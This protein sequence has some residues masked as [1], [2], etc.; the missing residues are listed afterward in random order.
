ML[1]RSVG[2]YLAGFLRENCVFDDE[3][4]RRSRARRTEAI[5]A[6]DHYESG[7]VIVKR[8]QL[9]DGRARAALDELKVRTEADGSKAR[10]QEERF[11]AE[12]AVRQLREEAA[13]A[14][15]ESAHFSAQNRW[16]LSG[17]LLIAL[18][19]SLAFWHLA[20]A[21]RRHSLLPVPT[22]RAGTAWTG[23]PAGDEEA[24][25]WRARALSAE[26]QAAQ[27]SAVVRAGLLPQFAR[28]LR[29]RLVRGLL[30][31][32]SHL[33]NT[34]ETAELEMAELER[35]LAELQAPLEQRL[36]AYQERI[37][38]LEQELT[39]KG[40]ENRELIKAKIELTRKKLASEQGQD[41]AKWN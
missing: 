12:T 13:R 33:L 24:A 1:A 2:R 14:E 27:A 22:G 23:S 28:W 20:R 40:E 11:A 17:L 38:E 25:A 10:S 31:E 16:L 7:E 26:Q 3:L 9:L 6:A 30:A 19:S 37:A 18:I 39:A 32:R 29:E 35:R 4:T 8:G 34:Q 5:F 36:R 41:P 15:F 21:R